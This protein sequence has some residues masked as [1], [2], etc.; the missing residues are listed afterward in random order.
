MNEALRSFGVSVCATAV[1]CAILHLLAPRDGTGRML[2]L[3]ASVLLIGCLLTP[4]VQI[5]WQ[6]ALRAPDILADDVRSEELTRRMMDQ[7]EEPLQQAVSQA[8]HEVLSNYGLAAEE[9]YA[10]MDIDES[11]GI[12]I[13]SITAVLNEKQALH[14][15]DVRQVLTA[16]FSVEVKIQEETD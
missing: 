6:A 7:L 2:E 1:I 12:Y 5:D 8:G 11:G 3:I 10:E 13:S 4:L 15:M 14:R 16:R 9:I